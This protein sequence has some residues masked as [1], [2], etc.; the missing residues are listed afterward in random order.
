MLGPD[1]FEVR[2]SC[3]RSYAVADNG[4]LSK[5]QRQ[6]LTVDEAT[7]SPSN[8]MPRLCARWHCLLQFRR[9]SERIPEN[10]GKNDS[11]EAGPEQTC[12]K[13]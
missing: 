8:E 12:E 5:T 2:R 9:I 3:R 13:K 11:R 6:T 1:F 4:D 10:Y 7:P